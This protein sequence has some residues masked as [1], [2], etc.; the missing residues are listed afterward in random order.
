MDQITG[1][2]Q[3]SKWQHVLGIQLSPNIY[4]KKEAVKI[5]LDILI[6]CF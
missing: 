1:P 4:I 2:Y 3:N 5:N 6:D